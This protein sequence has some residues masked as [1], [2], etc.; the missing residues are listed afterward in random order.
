MRS[1]SAYSEVPRL[2]AAFAPEY[3]KEHYHLHGRNIDSWESLKSIV[4]DEHFEFN[5]M[6]TKIIKGA[7]IGTAQGIL[8][9]NFFIRGPKR[10]ELDRLFLLRK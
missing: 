3:E 8:L 6:A 1:E 5:R 9:R 2:I 7:L 10:F 4:L